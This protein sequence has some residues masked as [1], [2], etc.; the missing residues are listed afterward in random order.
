MADGLAML[1]LA[2]RVRREAGTSSA[3]HI[4]TLA[5]VQLAASERTREE[6]RQTAAAVAS[7]DGVERELLTR[8]YL[9][10]HTMARVAAELHYTA[11]NCYLIRSKAIKSLADNL[12][13]QEAA[14]ENQGVDER[15]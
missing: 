10:G 14:R 11:Q 3:A 12:Q 4:E 15:C 2:Q 6:A 1:D 13:A 8:R 7:L 9:Q 5:H